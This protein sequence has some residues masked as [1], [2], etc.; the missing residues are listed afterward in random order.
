MK[1]FDLTSIGVKSNI[2]MCNCDVPPSTILERCLKNSIF[3]SENSSCT[4]CSFTSIEDLQFLTVKNVEDLSANRFM[5]RCAKIC[6]F[7]NTAIHTEILTGSSV[8]IKVSASAT[9]AYAYLL[10]DLFIIRYE[11]YFTNQNFT[12]YGNI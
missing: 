4:S 11:Y 12:S 6:G 10:L 9:S 2:K 7:C 3:I 1:V 5:N 8:F